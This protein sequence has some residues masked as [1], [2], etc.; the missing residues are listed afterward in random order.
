MIRWFCAYLSTSS[1][2]TYAASQKLHAV[3][4]PYVHVLLL[5]VFLPALPG[6]SPKP[7]GVRETDGRCCSVII[8]TDG[9]LDWCMTYCDTGGD[10]AIKGEDG[11]FDGGRLGGR[12]LGHRRLG[13]LVA[14]IEL[15]FSPVISSSSSTRRGAPQKIQGKASSY[16]HPQFTM[17]SCLVIHI[18]QTP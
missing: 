12:R 11:R 5:P 10:Q 13:G 8:S 7:A 3:A 15:P 16:T 6:V 1:S 17:L 18:L 14:L 2:H 9:L 4:D